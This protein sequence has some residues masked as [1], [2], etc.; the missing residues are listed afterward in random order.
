MAIHA[1][2]TKELFG[3]QYSDY[4]FLALI[5]Q[6][7]HLDLAFLNVKHRV[8]DIALREHILILLKFQYGLSRS[9]QERPE[10]QTRFCLGAPCQPPLS[11][12]IL[13]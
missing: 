4:R 8:R 10:R 11:K 7:S 6:D 5:G 12:W 1:A 13:G 3:S 9:W 2:F